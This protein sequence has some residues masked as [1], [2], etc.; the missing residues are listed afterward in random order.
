MASKA[1]AAL[2]ACA[3][4][5][6]TL[7]LAGCGGQDGA[8]APVMSA[9]RSTPSHTDSLATLVRR[10]T[11][12]R[13]ITALPRPPFVRP[14]L[15]ALGQALAFDKILSGN[16]DIS[17]MSCHL[18]AFATGDGRSLSVGAGG[19]GLGPSRVVPPGGFIP[20]NAPSVF[21]M[22]A[23]ES[24]FWDGRVF[25]DAGG[26]FHTPAGVQLTPAMTRVFE[27]GTLS[28]QPLFPVTSRA[29]MRGNSGNELAAIPDDDLTAIWNGL[30]V[31]L[32]AIP[33]YRRM[34]EAA[35]PGTS[36]DE[37]NFAYASNAI[38]GF[39][40]ARL[41]YANTPWDRFLAGDD[42]ALT[43]QQLE[44]AKDFMSAKC[45]ICHNGA[46]FTDNKFHDVAVA[47]IGP[48][49]GDG[50]S[51]HDD[52]GRMRVTGIPADKYTFR[53]TPLRNVELTGPWGHDGAYTTLRAFVDHYSESDVKLQTFDPG[54][55]E[56]A[57][58]GTL[59]PDAADILANRDP[60]LAGVV[61]TPQQIDDV[62]EFLRALTD[63]A[64]RNLSQLTP[65]HVP[66]GLPVDG[67]GADHAE[68]AGGGR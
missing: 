39:I 21:N 53:T 60:L 37:M 5:L 58:Q 64:A 13:G 66:S 9:A 54:P 1:S 38:A 6:G 26:G 68:L 40:T 31:R 16:H 22:A 20:R 47:Q 15:V 42:H 32:G 45:S 35:Y 34:F 49:E 33:A 63:P 65:G 46:A 11:A 57:L 55:L 48:G 10:L 3:A 17:C 52:F 41:S 28:A 36:F 24:A 43:G 62:T 61:F 25:R 4:L 7:A 67:A 51:G 12:G 8:T 44:G 50:A 56:P 59:Q 2:G 18:P 14:Q 27:F 19:T 30:M 29:E 23:L